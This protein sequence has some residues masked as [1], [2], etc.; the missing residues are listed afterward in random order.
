MR[1]VIQRVSRGK[2]SVDGNS[3]GSIGKGAVILLGI[4]VNDTE[5]DLRH[6]VDKCI[7][8]RIFEDSDGKMNLSLKEVGGEA[9]IVSQF[10]LYANCAK[11]RRP[12]FIEAARPDTAVPLYEKFISEFRS[13]GIKTETGIFG[14]MMDLEIHNDGPV[15]VII[16]SPLTD[17]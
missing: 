17:S 5:K 10:T 7:N 3:V 8:L 13:A 14:A 15:T 4:N 1:A 12:S 6:L 9:L 11:G 16:D 2:V